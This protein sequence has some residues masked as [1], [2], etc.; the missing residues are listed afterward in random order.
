MTFD[1]GYIRYVD[2]KVGN[3]SWYLRDVNTSDEEDKTETFIRTYECSPNE[4]A[5]TFDY[6]P[7]E[8]TEVGRKTSL[9]AYRDGVELIE[10]PITIA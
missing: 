5:P 6:V 8:K 3:I 9:V 7:T 4:L 2:G 10:L 1:W